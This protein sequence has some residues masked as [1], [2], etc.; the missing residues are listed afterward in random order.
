MTSFG[1]DYYYAN[2][3]V[4]GKMGEAI[5]M[6]VSYS[7]AKPRIVTRKTETICCKSTRSEQYSHL[8]IYSLSFAFVAQTH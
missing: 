8:H 5:L 1:I 3:Q 2:F 6:E 4:K 7:V